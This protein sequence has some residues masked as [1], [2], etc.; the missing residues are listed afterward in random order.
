MRKIKK[1]ILLTVLIPLFAFAGDAYF[2]YDYKCIPSKNH[3]TLSK[4]I[5][6]YFLYKDDYAREVKRIYPNENPESLGGFIVE[7]KLGS[8]VWYEVYIPREK[9]WKTG[10][11][12][13]NSL[14][15]EIMHI[16]EWKWHRGQIPSK[17]RL[18][19]GGR[20]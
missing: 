15:H 13:E 10:E 14:G 16:L 20:Q 2:E 19:K 3:Y 11:I 6:I 4:D 5:D 1:W 17:D 18:E 12:Y 9:D 8:R 7:Y